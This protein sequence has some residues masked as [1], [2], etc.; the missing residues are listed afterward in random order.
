MMRVASALSGSRVSLCR[1]ARVE[2]SVALAGIALGVAMAAFMLGGPMPAHAQTP[3]GLVAEAAPADARVEALVQ[4]GME[5]RRRHDD[6]EAVRLFESAVALSRDG[7]TLCQL[8]MAEAA[9]GRWVEAEQHLTE[10]LAAGGR[11]VEERRAELS[12]QREFVASHV[13]ELTILCETA[14]ATVAIAGTVHTLPMRGPVRVAVGQTEFTVE[15]RGHRPVTRTALVRAEHPSTETVRLVPIPAT[16]LERRHVTVA[17]RGGGEAFYVSGGIMMGLGLAGLAVGGVGDALFHDRRSVYDASVMSNGCPALTGG[18]V[19]AN[20]LPAS[21]RVT[22]AACFGLQD[23]WRAYDAM[24]FAG[25]IGGGILFGVGT[26]LMVIGIVADPGDGDAAS[27][28]T[29]SESPVRCGP[30][31]ELG[32]SC[33]A[34][35]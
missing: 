16:E 12:S 31:A 9:V 3:T 21:A 29:A 22:P 14:G 4:Q 1:S 18:A 6:A 24:R 11:W 17:R 33:A 35:F 19:P 15:A 28:E 34:V 13:G 27:E 20:F 26:I 7:R 30:F 8:G 32:L 25:Y 2:G 23:D 5:A 10:G